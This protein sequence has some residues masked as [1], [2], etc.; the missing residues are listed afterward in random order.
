MKY[1]FLILFLIV[2]F[3]CQYLWSK[4]RN[5]LTNEQKNIDFSLASKI[6]LTYLSLL[7]AGYIFIYIFPHKLSL[8][9]YFLIAIVIGI[10]LET[11]YYRRLKTLKFP[12]H[13]LRTSIALSSITYFMTAIFGLLLILFWY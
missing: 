5:S 1:L 3:T 8:L 11:F 13:Y 12:H 7:L 4:A 9:I 10:L 6:D 2:I